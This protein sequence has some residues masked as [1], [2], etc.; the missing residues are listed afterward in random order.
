MNF[1]AA[2]DPDK[3][4]GVS[5]DEFDKRFA[6]IIELTKQEAKIKGLPIQK[7]DKDQK[8]PYLEYPDGRREY[9]ES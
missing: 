3:I 5:D 2:N 6:A 8:A 1:M 4:L 7:W 9:C